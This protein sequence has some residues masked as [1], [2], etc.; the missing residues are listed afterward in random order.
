MKKCLVLVLFLSLLCG[1]APTNIS[2]LV[3]EL[4]NDRAHVHIEV[5]SVYGVVTYDREMPSGPGTNIE[6]TMRTTVKQLE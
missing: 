3:H 5:R 1:C 2:K 4:G 6:T